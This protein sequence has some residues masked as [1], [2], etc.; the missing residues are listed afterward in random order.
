MTKLKL[1][2]GKTT[3][4]ITAKAAAVEVQ[5]SFD[6][7]PDTPFT[8]RTDDPDGLFVQKRAEYQ[9]RGFIEVTS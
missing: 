1:T 2:R 7:Y 3:T 8:H 9:A 6:G 5:I 4:T